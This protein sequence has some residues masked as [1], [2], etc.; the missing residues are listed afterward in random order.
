MTLGEISLKTNIKRMSTL[1]LIAL[2]TTILLA[3]ISQSVLLASA[4]TDVATVIIQP[5]TG[6]TTDPASGTYT[7]ANG[8][9]FTFTATP[10]AGYVFQYWV[11][12]GNYTPGHTAQ[13][14]SYLIDPD[15]GQIIS[16]FPRPQVSGID[17]LITDVNPLNVSH[18]YGYTYSYQAVFAPISSAT[19]TP[20]PT[21]ANANLTAT[22]IIEASVG[23]TTNPAPGTYEYANGTQFSI[24][25]TPNAGFTFLYW[26]ISGNFTPGHNAAQAS[27]VL[28]EN[29]SFVQFPRPDLNGTDALTLTT[30]PADISHGYG[31][32]YAYQAVFIPTPAATSS[33]TPTQTA[34]PTA[35]PSPTPTSAPSGGLG[36]I[37]IVAIVV[38]VIII[39][40]AIAAVAMRRRK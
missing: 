14:P 32:T 28:S 5:S 3:A 19:P 16:A 1:S 4:Q 18:G 6:G 17:S 31:Y 38:V 8:T 7:Y 27:F 9:Q 34:A 30:N 26:V 36:T 13:S 29:G 23:G 21:G 35:S 40:V 24:S 12:T 25:A 20:T 39:I 11:I 10:D 15:T 2:V 37:Y 33:P 22:V